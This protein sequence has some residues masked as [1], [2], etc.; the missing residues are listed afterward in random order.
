VN[1][2]R[3]APLAPTPGKHL[4]AVMSSSISG[5]INMVLVS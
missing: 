5:L 1:V 2:I 4:K 3:C